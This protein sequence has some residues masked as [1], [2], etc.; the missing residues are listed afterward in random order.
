MLVSHEE[1]IQSGELTKKLVVEMNKTASDAFIKDH[2]Q[3]QIEDREKEFSWEKINSDKFDILK[4]TAKIKL[5]RDKWV[6]HKDSKRKPIIIQYDEIDKV[7]KF[8]EEKVGEY[9][10]FLTDASM[11]SFLPTG[12]EGDE[13]IFS[14]AWT[15]V[16]Q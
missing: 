10:T 9:H 1:V 12:I 5:F 15:D 2:F 7:I 13:E 14:F 16:K 8:I 4:E 3:K 11:D 6:A